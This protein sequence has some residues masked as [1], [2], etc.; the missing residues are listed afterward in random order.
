MHVI[1][2]MSVRV[3]ACVHACWLAWVSEWVSEWVKSASVLASARARVNISQ[4]CIWTC[5]AGYPAAWGCCVILH[6]TTRSMSQQ[7]LY[8]QMLAFATKKLST[9]TNGQVDK[10]WMQL[11]PLSTQ[12]WSS[13][14]CTSVVLSMTQNAR[15][16]GSNPTLA[17][18]F[19]TYFERYRRFIHQI[20]YLFKYEGLQ[21]GPW[22]CQAKCVGP[23]QSK[24]NQQD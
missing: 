7:R 21:E 22:L 23:S 14:H 3:C 9:G 20:F 5:S 24:F 13:C 1:A 15:G 18:L 17:K 10:R 19:K 11:S 12:F 8:T 2:S 16:P 6:V 4:L